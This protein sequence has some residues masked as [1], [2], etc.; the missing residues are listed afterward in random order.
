MDELTWEWSESM[1][2]RV[3][4]LLGVYE[5]GEVQKARAKTYRV[6]SNTNT[7]FF[8]CSKQRKQTIKE[9][10][11]LS[12]SNPDPGKGEHGAVFEQLTS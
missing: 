9:V 6:G 8:F 11:A 7:C 3:A 10:N 4:W 5:D 2:V 1:L 12:G